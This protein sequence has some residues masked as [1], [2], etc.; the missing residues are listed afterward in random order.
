V[1]IETLDRR[2]HP[3]IDTVRLSSASISSLREALNK[4]NMYVM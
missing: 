4:S 2:G 3:I 1:D